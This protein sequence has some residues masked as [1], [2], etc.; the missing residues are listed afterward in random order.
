VQIP[1]RPDAF[2]VGT[3]SDGSATSTDIGLLEGEMLDGLLSRLE[4]IVRRSPAPSPDA[5]D[6][7]RP[8]ARRRSRS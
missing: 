4:S 8:S 5:G 2:P 1:T 7:T 3:R 6:D